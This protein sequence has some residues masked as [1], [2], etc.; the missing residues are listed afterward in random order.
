VKAG[1]PVVRLRIHADFLSDLTSQLAWLAREGQRERI[2]RLEGG[3]DEVIELLSEFPSVGVLEATEGR[4]QLRRLILRRLPFVV[5]FRTGGSA[6]VWLLRLFHVRQ[7]RPRTASKA[8][9]PRR[10]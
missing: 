9:R 7:D 6:D 1:K 10:R 2:D 5:W 3:I 4:T 8:R